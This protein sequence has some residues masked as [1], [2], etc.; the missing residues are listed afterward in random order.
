MSSIPLSIC[1]VDGS[2]ATLMGKADSE[3]GSRAT[4]RLPGP[5]DEEDD[6][7]SSVL[8]NLADVCEGA[9]W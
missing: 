4:L 6:A 9:S 5:A 1:E 7:T 8:R 3:L 2:R